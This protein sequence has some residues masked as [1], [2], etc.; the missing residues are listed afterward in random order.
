[1]IVVFS[2]YLPDMQESD[3]SAMH[4]EAINPTCFRRY[5]GIAVRLIFFIII[6]IFFL[7]EIR[8]TVIWNCLLIRQAEEIIAKG[9]TT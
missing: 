7:I 3:R 9:T 6:I 2:T 1:M 4:R 8:M 5:R